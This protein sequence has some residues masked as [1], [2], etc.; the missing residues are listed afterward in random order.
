MC[1]CN[2][3]KEGTTRCITQVFG[4]NNVEHKRPSHKSSLFIIIILEQL[5]KWGLVN[6]SWS[7][8]WP[9][10]PCVFACRLSGNLEI[11]RSNQR[12]PSHK[13]L[14]RLNTMRGT[15]SWTGGHACKQQLAITKIVCHTGRGLLISCVAAHSKSPWLRR[16]RLERLWQPR[17]RRVSGGKSKRTNKSLTNFDLWDDG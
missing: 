2:G 11:T 5:G 12:A 7:G 10:G 17:S 4:P 13:L 6:G 15:F 16:S 1:R 9:S 3:V 8:H 14:L